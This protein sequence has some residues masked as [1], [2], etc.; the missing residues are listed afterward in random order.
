MK[1]NSR[2]IT[3]FPSDIT[4]AVTV[5]DEPATYEPLPS[6]WFEE[7]AELIE[8][9]LTF[10]PRTPP[11]LILDATVNAGRFWRG[12]NRQII[13]LDIE[14]K[15]RP[16]IVGDNMRMPFANG[17]LD[18]VVYDPPHIPNQGRDQQKD[19]NSRFGLVLKSGPAT[20]YSFSHFYPPFAAEAFRVL[21][22]E[23]I[24]LC[25]IAD[26]VHNHRTHWAHFDMTLAAREAG[27][28]AC[29]CIVKVRKGPIVDPRWKLAHHARR[30]HCYW[31]IFRKSHK[32]E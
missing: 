18:V 17:C 2:Q 8:R 25:K 12:S 26:Y 10:Y 15:R 3:L 7:D 29:D 28:M 14:G 27:F 5:H 13:G 32:C 11:K 22:P 23:G 20:G 30:Q 16:T 19:F 9:M 24:L 31:L 1:Q 4:P 21:K 6:V